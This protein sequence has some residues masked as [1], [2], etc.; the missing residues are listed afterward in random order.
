[1][2]E[3]IWDADAPIGAEICNGASRE[4]IML[5]W[6]KTFSRSGRKPRGL[7]MVHGFR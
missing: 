2:N 7:S 5:E 3:T 6:A 1:M 4:W